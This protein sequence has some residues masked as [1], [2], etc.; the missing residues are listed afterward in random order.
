MI[1]KIVKDD[2]VKNN[3]ILFAGSMVVAVLNYAYHPILSR[4]M[5]VENFGEVQAMIA[6]FL[7]SGVV[8][9]IFGNIVINLTANSDDKEEK[10]S[11]IN[12]LF[13]IA[14]IAGWI[15][16]ILIIIFTPFLKHFLKFQS[17]W[18]FWAL[19]ISLPLSVS[20]TFRR[21]FLQGKKEFIKVSWVSI[22]YAGGRLV[23]A[24]FLV[25][26]GFKTLGA[27]GAITLSTLFTLLYAYKL[28][29]QCPD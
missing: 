19:A 13:K 3:I 25:W 24:I 16:T 2:F 28:T 11:L 22:L 29:H 6:L 27:I 20:L 21:F 12:Q 26:L 4:M 1:R 15:L 17:I 14:L 23:I 5:S 7:Q 10:I 8:L 18:A 9:G